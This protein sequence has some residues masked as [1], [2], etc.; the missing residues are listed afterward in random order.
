[1]EPSMRGESGGVKKPTISSPFDAVCGDLLRRILLRLPNTASLVNAALACKRWRRAASDPTI[2]RRFLPLVGFILTNHGDSVIYSCPNHYFISA[3]NH[4]PDIDSGEQCSGGYY[5]KWRLRGCDDGCLLLS[6]G[7][8]GFDLTVYDPLS[9][10]PSSSLRHKTSVGRSSRY[11]IVIVDNADAS[12]RVI[13]IDGDMFFTI[14]S[15]STGKWALFDHTA[16]L[17]EQNLQLWV[18][19]GSSNGGW[20]LKTEISLFDQFRYLKKLWREEWMKRERVLAAKAGYVYMEFWSIRKPNSYLPVHNL[21]TMKL[22]I[23][24]NDSDEPF[25]GP[26][27]RF[28]LRLAPLAPSPDDANDRRHGGA[29]R[30]GPVVAAPGAAAVARRTGG[31]CPRGDCDVGKGQHWQRCSRAGKRRQRRKQSKSR[32]ENVDTGYKF[33][34]SWGC[35]WCYF[36]FPSTGTA[37]VH[38]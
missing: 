3:T 17:K 9:R 13:G 2:F 37:T 27:L 38:L 24:C 33:V 4:V 12:F 25:R 6:H 31:S 19:S 11:A 18:R 8:G 23:I 34:T 20:L 21:N 15:S 10:M 26:A 29:Q 28:F 14:F 22:D 32:I 1:M 16:D 7:C 5:D 36:S 30:S 35:C